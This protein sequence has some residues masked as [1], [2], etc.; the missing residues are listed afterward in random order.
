MIAAIDLPGPRGIMAAATEATF[1]TST[2]ALFAG[3]STG[4][5]SGC[6]STGE[7]GAKGRRAKI[8]VKAAELITFRLFGL[9]IEENDLSENELLGTTEG[10]H[11]R[12]G[13]A[14]VPCV[15]AG[16]T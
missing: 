10:A 12:P 7:R 11:T 9:V 5:D 15:P 1:G 2:R 6:G 13:W 14:A 4:A 3:A 8:K 16:G